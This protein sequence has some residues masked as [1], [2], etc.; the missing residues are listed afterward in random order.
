[1]ELQLYSCT[2]GWT[3]IYIYYC[4]L[5]NPL[6][7]EYGVHRDL[8]TAAKLGSVMGPLTEVRHLRINNVQYVL[9][10]I[11][12]WKSTQLWKSSHPY[13]WPKVQAK[14]KLQNSCRFVP[15][16]GW[17]S[18]YILDEFSFMYYA[19]LSPGKYIHLFCIH[20]LLEH[21]VHRGLYTT[22]KDTKPALCC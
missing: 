2:V 13:F 6:L 16:T 19:W 5:W 21:G 8:C 12:T 18:S 9:Y 4:Y 11:V 20:A 1:M 3:H 22:K 15:K 7:L 17:N 10:Y 14:H